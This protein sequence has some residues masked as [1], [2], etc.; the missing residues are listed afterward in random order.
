[1][2]PS[3]QFKSVWVWNIIDIQFAVWKFRGYRNYIDGN[4]VDAVKDVGAN[5]MC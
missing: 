4:G 2:A 5:A 1:M 3:P